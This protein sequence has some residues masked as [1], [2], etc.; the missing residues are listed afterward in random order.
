M[1][2]KGCADAVMS[3]GRVEIF[4]GTEVALGQWRPG[5]RNPAQDGRAKKIVQ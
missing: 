2:T 1:M 4:L 5:Q 3:G